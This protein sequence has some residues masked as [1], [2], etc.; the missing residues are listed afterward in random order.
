MKRRSTKKRELYKIIA[1]DSVK[2]GGRDAH[3]NQGWS[4]IPQTNEFVLLQSDKL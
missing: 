1:T 4:L 2:V 3:K